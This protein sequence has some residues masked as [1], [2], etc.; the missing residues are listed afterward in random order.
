MDPFVE[1]ILERYQ[2]INPCIEIV[3]SP[4]L[5]NE[6]EI[7]H[8]YL[9]FDIYINRESRD[10]IQKQIFDKPENR[11]QRIIYKSYFTNR[12]DCRYYSFLDETTER[13]VTLPEDCFTKQNWSDIQLVIYKY[14]E[15]YACK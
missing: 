11:V 6:L 4:L 3:G 13:N 8:P 10:S 7:D 14:E 15:D 2:R 5:P 12:D 1:F 9:M